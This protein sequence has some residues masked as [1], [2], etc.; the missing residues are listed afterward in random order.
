MVNI[1]QIFFDDCSDLKNSSLISV[2][3][4]TNKE[5]TQKINS[6]IISQPSNTPL[7]K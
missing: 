6:R 7:V 5:A 4:Q 3:G 2:A 1:A